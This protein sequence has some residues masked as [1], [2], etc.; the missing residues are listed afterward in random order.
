MDVAH[1]V[2]DTNDVILY[3]SCKDMQMEASYAMSLHK[4]EPNEFA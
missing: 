3:R 2:Y 4:T 1:F